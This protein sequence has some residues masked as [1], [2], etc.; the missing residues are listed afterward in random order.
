MSKKRTHADTLPAP[1][2]PLLKPVH[3]RRI[4]KRKL[5]APEASSNN[6]SDSSADTS[7]PSISEASTLFSTD[8]SYSTRRSSDTEQSEPSDGDGDS[9]SSELAE[10]SEDTD[11][12]SESN[13]DMSE[14]D[15]ESESENSSV[16]TTVRVGKKPEM[17]RQQWAPGLD[18]E[19]EEGGQPLKERLKAFLPQIAAANMELEEEKAAGV[20]DERSLEQANEGDD[21][22]GQYIEMNLGLGVL[23]ERDPNAE[24]SNSS[25]D[26]EAD[27]RDPMQDFE[28]S[29]PRDKNVMARLLGRNRRTDKVG[30]QE[31][32]S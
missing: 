20:L 16:I 11:T 28:G 14:E 10:S 18:G 9:E 2:H 4:V 12:A 5:S 22:D 3:T 21:V 1:T 29:L 32:D 13:E 30:I 25:E 19:A 15:G 26:E 31:V 6:D 8:G 17:R 23:E 7:G 27:N 24:S